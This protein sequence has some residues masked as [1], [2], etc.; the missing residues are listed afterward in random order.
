MKRALIQIYVM[1]CDA[2]YLLSAESYASV[3]ICH[4]GSP[5]SYIVHAVANALLLP[6]HIAVSSRWV[7]IKA[8]G[9]EMVCIVSY[10]TSRHLREKTAAGT[11]GTRKSLNMVVK[12]EISSKGATWQPLRCDII[13]GFSVKQ[14]VPDWEWKLPGLDIPSTYR[15][16]INQYLITNRIN[17]FLGIY[18][19]LFFDV[20][21][22]IIQPFIFYSFPCLGDV[23]VEGGG[24]QLTSPAYQVVRIC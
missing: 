11:E 8:C 16:N 7:I 12:A 19:V 23:V 2:M 4:R 10:A 6:I 5:T 15:M 14:S 13:S 1:Q 3:R 20:K 22:R 24:W 18:F 21:A 17:Y 9:G